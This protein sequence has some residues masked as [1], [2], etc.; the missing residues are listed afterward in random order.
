M[1]PPIALTSILAALLLAACASKSDKPQRF[2]LR[3]FSLAAPAAVEGGKQWG[4][5]KR[6]QDLLILGKPG[7]YESEIFV[8]QAAVIRL[9]AL[10]SPDALLQHVKAAQQRELD[11]KRFRVLR[12]EL[13]LRPLDGESCALSHIEAVDRAIPGTTGPTANMML[14]TLTLTCAHPNDRNT[15]INV[16]YSHQYFPED[17]DPRFV[18]KGSVILEG[19]RLDGKP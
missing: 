19:L 14:E 7:N 3:G 10:A 11:P 6:T 2:E 15:G 12:H 18:E 8:V 1:K 9:P 13:S 5:A 17:K 4:V 16:T